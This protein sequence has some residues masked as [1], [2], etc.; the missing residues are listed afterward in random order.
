M[1]VLH[2]Y[3][4]VGMDVIPIAMN[5]FTPSALLLYERGLFAQESD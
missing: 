3:T 2:I 1:V 4:G 5:G